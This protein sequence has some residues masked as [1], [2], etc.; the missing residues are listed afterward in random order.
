VAS[1]AK[2]CP[3][4]GTSFVT[5]AQLELPFVRCQLCKLE[6]CDHYSMMSALYPTFAYFPQVYELKSLSFLVDYRLYYEYIWR[7]ELPLLFGLH[8][9]LSVAFSSQARRCLSR[10]HG[11]YRCLFCL[12]RDKVI[13]E[14]YLNLVPFGNHTCA[15]LLRHNFLKALHWGRC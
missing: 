9:I 5:G 4:F 13:I 8:L 14:Q 1:F 2:I 6:F 7:E 10:P 3:N 11:A 12:R 15:A